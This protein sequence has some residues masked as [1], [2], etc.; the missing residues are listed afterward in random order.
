MCNAATAR[1]YAASRTLS[2]GLGRRDVVDG[3]EQ[4]TMFQ[5]IKPFE[6]GTFDDFEDATDFICGHFGL[7]EAVNR[8]GQS[9]VVAVADAANR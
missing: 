2:F 8:F 6:H 7:V 1:F 4:A 5:T 3:F 9:V